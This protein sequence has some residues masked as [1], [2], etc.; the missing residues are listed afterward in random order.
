MLLVVF[1][2]GGST[3]Q[4]PGQAPNDTDMAMNKSAEQRPEETPQENP[5]EEPRPEGPATLT[6]DVTV[7]GQPVASEIKV[8]NASGEVV[9]QGN[10]GQTFQIRSG[11]YT[12]QIQVTDT[13]AMVDKPTKVLDLDLEPGSEAHE[14]A[15]FPWTRIRLNV[16]VKGQINKKAK[17]KLIRNGEAVATIESAAEAYVTISPGHY[18][19]EVSVGTMTTTL[20]DVMLSEGATRDVPIDV[21]F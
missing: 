3:S 19:A 10:S 14:T 1:G 16:K 13:K 2:C 18:K 15:S 12:A 17:V 20:D 11:H 7:K 4:Q 9:A 5:I 8:L 6:I 21:N